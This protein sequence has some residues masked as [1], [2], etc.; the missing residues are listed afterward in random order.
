MSAPTRAR[1]AAL[2]VLKGH[3]GQSFGPSPWI[4]VTQEMITQ[5]G[6]LTQD[7]HFIHMDPAR[8]AQ[9]ALGG[10]I[11]HGFLS[12]SF[13]SR[14]SYDSFTAIPGV[15]VALNYGFDRV[16]FVHPVRPG[17]RV[18]GR[19]TL[20]EATPRG[21]EGIL[22]TAALRVDIDGED[23]PAVSADWLALFLF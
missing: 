22:R 9:T 18:R 11:A 5:F 21:D 4:D 3:V 16:R 19:F 1:D 8:A 15:R 7:D 10:T 2:E 17:Q 14:F 6:T 12:L 23:K 20:L 13:A